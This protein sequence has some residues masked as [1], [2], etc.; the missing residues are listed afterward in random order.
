[1][2]N[3]VALEAV[4]AHRW[5]NMHVKADKL[6]AFHKSAMRLCDPVSKARYQGVTDR[7]IEQKMQPVPWWFIAIASEREYS[8]PPHWDKQLGQGDPLNQRSH[9]VPANMGPYL[10]HEGDVTPG[11]DAWTR[12]CVDVL[13]NSAPYAA[14]WPLWTIGGVLTLWEEF[15][16]LG[17]AAMGVPSAYV[18]S[19]SDVYISGKYVRDHVYNAKYIDVQEGTAPLLSMMMAID[20][21]IQIEGLTASMPTVSVPTVATPVLVS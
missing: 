16:G 9:N 1:M 18:W 10:A 2:V 17:Y 21:S 6:P 14:K 11:H 5:V 13:I 7:L 19:G 3:I 4:N 20:S 8:G 15:N 12:C